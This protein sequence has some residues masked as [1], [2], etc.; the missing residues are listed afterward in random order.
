MGLV[1]E[2]VVANHC[3]R[4]K[5]N[6]EHGLDSTIFY[7]SDKRGYEVDVVVELFKKPLLIEVKYQENVRVRA[8]WYT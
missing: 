3:R 2:N 1:T 4:L 6:L 8:C 5:F 7:W